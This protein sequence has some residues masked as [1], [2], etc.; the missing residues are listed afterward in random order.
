MALSTVS[1]ATLSQGPV[2]QIMNATHFQ[3]RPCTHCG[4]STVHKTSRIH[5]ATSVFTNCTTCNHY[6]EE[7]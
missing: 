6:Y 1:Q 3:R 5:G 2:P 4:K 7:A